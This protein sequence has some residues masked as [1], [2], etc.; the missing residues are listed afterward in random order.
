VLVTGL[1][2]QT[3]PQIENI[4]VRQLPAPP[5]APPAAVAPDTFEDSFNSGLR[6]EW[7][8]LSGGWDMA[9]DRLT[10]TRLH[11]A[12]T[13]TGLIAVSGVKWAQ[14]RVEASITDLTTFSDETF[15]FEGNSAVGLM[16]RLQPDGSGIGVVVERRALTL[17]VRGADGAWTPLPEARVTGMDFDSPHRVQLVA[18]GSTYTVYLDRVQV[19]SI[20]YEGGPADGGIG[21]WMRSAIPINLAD[22]TVVPKVD[23]FR[24]SGQP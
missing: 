5:P 7:T 23:D 6:P 4:D 13:S 9:R 24:A 17:A 11:P 22:R 15:L 16:A 10:L 21:V 14:A 2:G 1:D 19:L 8:I 20:V 12:E 3:V 18:S